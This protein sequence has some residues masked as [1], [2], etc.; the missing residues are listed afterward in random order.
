MMLHVPGS[1]GQDQ[2]C[3]TQTGGEA[4]EGEEVMSELSLDMEE[5]EECLPD[6]RQDVHKG[7][8]VRWS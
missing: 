1:L 3:L 6:S 8:A 7:T 2:E 4:R 5:E